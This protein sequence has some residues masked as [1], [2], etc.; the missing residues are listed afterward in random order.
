ML[1]E[2]SE[3]HF[4]KQKLHLP[5]ITEIYTAEFKDKH[6]DYFGSI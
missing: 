6:A 5:I 4:L 1:A 3:L 2:Y